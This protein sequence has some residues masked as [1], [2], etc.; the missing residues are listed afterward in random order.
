MYIHR[1]DKGWN[2]Y[3]GRGCKLFVPSQQPPAL[4]D[5]IPLASNSGHLPW[6]ARWF[7]P[8]LNALQAWMTLLFGGPWD[9]CWYETAKWRRRGTIGDRT[10]K[11]E[12]E[13]RPRIFFLCAIVWP[14]N[15]WLEER[16]DTNH[17]GE[18]PDGSAA[19]DCPSTPEGRDLPSAAR[20]FSWPAA[21]QRIWWDSRTPGLCQATAADGDCYL[22]QRNVPATRLVKCSTQASAVCSRSGLRKVAKWNAWEY[23]HISA[24]PPK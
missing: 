5:L 10:R 16:G 24:L 7:R 6:S 12:W 8:L 9:C 15:L 21:P 4:L 23:Q 17:A 19:G 3:G 20:I 14:L 18:A 2:V 13:K 22:S 1:A 11:Y